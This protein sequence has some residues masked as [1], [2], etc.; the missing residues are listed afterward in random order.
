MDSYPISKVINGLMNQCHHPQR[1][2]I[3]L[4]EGLKSCQKAMRAMATKS[5][6]VV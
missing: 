6:F 3:I 4:L 1:F 5:R 2:L